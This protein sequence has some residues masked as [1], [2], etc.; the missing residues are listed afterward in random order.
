MEL[1]PPVKS[2]PPYG[3]PVVPEVRPAVEGGPVAELVPDALLFLDWSLG[4]TQVTWVYSS[5]GGKQGQ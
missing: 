3:V 4:Q 1:H 2:L 5:L